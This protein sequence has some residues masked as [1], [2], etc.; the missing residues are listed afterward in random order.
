MKFNV[1][2][3]L[4][5]LMTAS[6]P[7]YVLKSGSI[8][9]SHAIAIVTMI[10]CIANDRLTIGV[11]ESILITLITCMLFTEL[12]HAHNIIGIEPILNIAF[13]VF[14]LLFVAMFRKV[15]VSKH[16][17]VLYGLLT[18][19]FIALMGLFI[20]GFSFTGP[21]SLRAVGFF[22]NPN[23]LGYFAVLSFSIVALIQMLVDVDK[24]IYLFI[25]ICSIFFSILSL[26]KAAMVSLAFGL[27]MLGFSNAPFRVIFLLFP[28][29]YSLITLFFLP[30]LEKLNFVKRIGDIGHSGDDNLVERG[31]FV[32]FQE[33]E[34]VLD[35]IFG[36]GVERALFALKHEVHSTFF[37]FLAYY[38]FVGFI[39]YFSF[40][41]YVVYQ[42]LKLVSFKNVLVIMSPPLLFGLTHNGS[43]SL[44]FVLLIALILAS[45]SQN[46]KRLRKDPLIKS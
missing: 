24:S 4:V 32:L 15:L 11:V 10:Y 8:Q 19:Q 16:I 42:L 38:G 39:L 13:M 6:F 5:F 21:E 26:S 25:I 9:P 45:A 23:Q 44:F 29:V 43:R 14:T 28:V 12:I 35:Y 3:C 31:T 20:Y 7:L 46:F 1:L 37:S 41:G 33:S 27:L 2:S 36:I 34:G 18:S 30:A 40:F 22:N 17:E